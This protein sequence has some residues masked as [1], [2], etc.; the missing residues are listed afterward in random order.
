M[1]DK[2]PEKKPETTPAAAPPPSVGSILRARRQMRGQSLDSV[3]QAT[4]IP[5]GLLQSLEE[6]RHGDFAAPVYLHGFLKSYCDHLEL[7]YLPLWQRV[8]PPE[9]PAPEDADDS[10]PDFSRL[11]TPG[12]M[13]LFVLG[14]LLAVGVAVWGVSRL[15]RSK[16]DVPPAPVAVEPTAPAAPVALEPA[17]STAAAAVPSSATAASTGPVSLPALPPQPEP[18][19][20][21]ARLRITSTAGAQVTLRR[22]GRLVFEGRLPPGKHLDWRGTTFVLHT[23]NPKGLRVD[24]AGH[25]VDL[26]A[27]RPES[28]GSFRL[29]KK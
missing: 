3:H 2:Q 24:L 9:N 1:S 12:L 19:S 21:P 18:V 11:A 7:D 16:P 15:S 29:G 26:A 27:L 5:R 23:S 13:P 10:G 4:R 25:P 17:P 6:D 8:A 22:D 28:D 14:G 20:Y